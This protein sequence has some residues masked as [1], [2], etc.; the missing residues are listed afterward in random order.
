MNAFAG[1]EWFCAP[2]V[3]LSGEYTWG[4]AFSS[5]GAGESTKDTFVVDANGTSG[6]VVSTT[7]EGTRDDGIADKSSSFGIDT[8]VTG[9]R[10]G[11]N[12]YFQ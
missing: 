12:F 9:A 8:G 1:V 7:N 5:T 3:S 10:I 6:S 2:K 11:L 4:F